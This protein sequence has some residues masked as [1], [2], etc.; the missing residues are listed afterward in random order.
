MAYPLNVTC[1]RLAIGMMLGR[2]EWNKLQRRAS[3]FIM[4]KRRMRDG[5]G[6]RHV[7]PLVA[8]SISTYIDGRWIGLGIVSRG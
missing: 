4:L 7:A 1:T 2:L 8:Y 6:L 5:G 3:N